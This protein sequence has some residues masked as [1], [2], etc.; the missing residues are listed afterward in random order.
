MSVIVTAAAIVGT[1]ATTGST[2]GTVR[3]TSGGFA[4]T[5]TTAWMDVGAAAGIAT[6][7]AAATAIKPTFV[8]E[9]GTVTVD[10][11]AAS[12]GADATVP[13]ERQADQ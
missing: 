5:I 12:S 9:P 10:D 7:P 6:I 13:G 1:I 2:S 3:R 4:A 8:M 11:S